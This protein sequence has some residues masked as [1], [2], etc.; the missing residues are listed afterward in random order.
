MTF[1]IT[2]GIAKHNSRFELL[3]SSKSNKEVFK[4][5]IKRGKKKKTQT[6]IDLG[7]K[8]PLTDYTKF[9]YT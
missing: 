1:G 3:M 5:D 2:Q 4:D 8:M 6:N 7:K 9:N